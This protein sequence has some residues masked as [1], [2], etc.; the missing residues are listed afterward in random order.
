MSESGGSSNRHKG[1]IG[2][3]YI[4]I[5]TV[6]KAEHTYQQGSH[7]EKAQGGGH[8]K[9]GRWAQQS[10]II[11]SGREPRRARRSGVWSQGCSG[12]RAWSQSEG[13]HR[14]CLYKSAGRTDSLNWGCD[15]FYVLDAL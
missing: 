9:G 12:R 6:G 13:T 7:S 2:D 11:P 1:F 10:G 8:T 4:H 15:P 14:S 3:T 5:N